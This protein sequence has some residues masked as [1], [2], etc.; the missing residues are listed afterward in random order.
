MKGVED[1]ANIV[2]YLDMTASAIATKRKREK[3]ELGQT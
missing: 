2:H 3:R 1:K